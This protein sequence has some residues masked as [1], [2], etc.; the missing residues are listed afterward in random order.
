MSSQQNAEWFDI[1]PP[2]RCVSIAGGVGEHV[3]PQKGTRPQRGVAGP[4]IEAPQRG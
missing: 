1:A 4:A 2:K 3:P